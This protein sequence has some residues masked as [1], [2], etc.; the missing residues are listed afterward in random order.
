VEVLVEPLQVLE[1]LEALVED[2]VSL[3]TLMEEL[4]LLGKDLMVVVQLTPITLVV[5]VVQE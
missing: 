3:Q 5:V 1:E 2:L 4:E